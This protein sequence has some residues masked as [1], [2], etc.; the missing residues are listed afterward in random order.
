MNWEVWAR[1]FSRLVS[2]AVFTIGQLFKMYFLTFYINP[3]K[4]KAI[5]GTP[6]RSWLM[7]YATSRKVAGSSPDE[8]IGFFIGP[9]PSSRTMA[10]RSIHPL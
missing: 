9:N 5:G 1:Q 2:P 10:L 3:A 8:V 6:Y 7:H 4:D